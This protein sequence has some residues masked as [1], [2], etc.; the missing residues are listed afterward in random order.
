[1]QSEREK[2][3]RRKTERKKERKSYIGVAAGKQVTR[4][5][6]GVYG[7]SKTRKRELRK[8]GK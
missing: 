2:S 8:I 5:R 1:M 3:E 6:K 4:V 7:R